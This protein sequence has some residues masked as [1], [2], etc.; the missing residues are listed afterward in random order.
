M[1]PQPQKA[2]PVWA[3][4]VMVTLLGLTVPFY[5]PK[6]AVSPVVLGLPIWAFVSFAFSVL[7]A[8]F[9]AWIIMT[10]WSKDDSA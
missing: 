3:W 7:F 6:D 2:I 5:W 1:M 9:T 8:C 4:C 10:F